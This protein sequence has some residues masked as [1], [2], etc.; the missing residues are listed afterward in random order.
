M[1]TSTEIIFPTIS[2][3]HQILPCTQT[4][5]IG[6]IQDSSNKLYSSPNHI[7]SFLNE[8]GVSYF[9]LFGHLTYVFN[10]CVKNKSISALIIGI[11]LNFLNNKH[12]ITSLPVTRFSAIPLSAIKINVGANWTSA[13]VMSHFLLFLTEDWPKNVTHLHSFSWLFLGK[14]IKSIHSFLN[15]I[16]K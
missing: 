9:V 5:N 8:I 1:L 12:I 6:V 4:W 13:N 7:V 14:I 15:P 3:A 2:H 10:M 11:F 16:M